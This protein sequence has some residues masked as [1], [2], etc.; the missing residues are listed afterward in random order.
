MNLF[1]LYVRFMIWLGAAPPKG[2]EYLLPIEE[3][4]PMTEIDWLPSVEQ[5]SVMEEDLPAWLREG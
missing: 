4:M 1:E 3:R 5:E 2:Y